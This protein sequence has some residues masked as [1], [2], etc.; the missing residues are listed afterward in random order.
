MAVSEDKVRRIGD[1]LAGRM[2]VDELV[3]VIVGEKDPESF[4]ALI[5]HFQGTVGWEETILLPLSDHL[6]IAARDAGAVVKCTCGQ[7][8]TDYRVNWKV[9]ARVFVRQTAEQFQELYPPGMHPEPGWQ[10][11]R[12]YYC[13][14]CYALLQVETVPP[15]YPPVFEFLPDLQTLYRDWLGRR[16]PVEEHEFRDLT[17]EWLVRELAPG[18]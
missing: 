3:G 7:E 14:G 17:E 15:G 10:E 11:I 12:E 5:A 13:P 4:D 9:R 6:M 1:M 8:F 18:S 16:L 2:P